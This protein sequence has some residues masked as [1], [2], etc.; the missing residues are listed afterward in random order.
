MLDVAVSSPA[1]S[2]ESLGAAL[3]TSAARV[4]LGTAALDNPGWVRR[5]IGT[6]GHRIA[7]GLDARRTALSAR[8]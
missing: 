7:V 8:R 4:N 6:R 2:D 1:A 3:T 5:V